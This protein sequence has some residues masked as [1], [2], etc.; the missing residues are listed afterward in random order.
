MSVKRERRERITAVFICAPAVCLREKKYLQPKKYLWEENLSCPE[1]CCRE[2]LNPE[3]GAKNVCHKLN[4][5]LLHLISSS[6]SHH[7]SSSVLWRSTT[8]MFARAAFRLCSCRYDNCDRGVFVAT[9]MSRIKQIVFISPSHLNWLT[10][11]LFTPC[12]SPSSLNVKLC[13][14]QVWLQLES[15][16]TLSILSM[17]YLNTRSQDNN[18]R[19]FALGGS[20][21]F[22]SWGE[23]R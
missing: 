14:V 4:N 12:L 1:F 13:F 15:G 17:L 20:T 18:T 5:W 9:I 8:M 19:L 16:N 22:F 10:A 6:V 21:G 7:K 11:H 23:C 3:S 2:V